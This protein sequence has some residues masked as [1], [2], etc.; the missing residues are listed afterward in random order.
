MVRK[1]FDFVSKSDELPQVATNPATMPDKFMLPTRSIDLQT[2]PYGFQEIPADTH[3][4]PNP[5]EHLTKDESVIHTS[6][7]SLSSLS[8]DKVTP[9]RIVLLGDR[10]VGKTALDTQVIL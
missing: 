5:D 6:L 8:V 10:G 9:Y 3:D 2:A 7:P 4:Y 1:L